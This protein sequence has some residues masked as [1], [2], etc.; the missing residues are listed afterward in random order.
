MT[1]SPD[2]RQ[3]R[4]RFVAFSFAAADLLMEIEPEHGLIQFV[5]GAAKS[6]TGKTDAELKNISLYNLLLPADR[7]LFRRFL[8]RIAHGGRVQPLPIKIV[9]GPGDHKTV[10]MGGCRLPYSDRFYV[11]VVQINKSAVR[12]N[13]GALRDE[14][15]GLL[16][17]D[18]FAEKAHSL[19]ERQT[20]EQGYQLTFIE[21]PG[22]D[23]LAG[24]M[25]REKMEEL[26]SSIGAYLRASSA[27][28]DAATVVEENRYGVVHAASITASDLKA[29]IEELTR[30]YDPAH[31]GIEG[32]T[33]EVNLNV[34][35][36]GAEDTTKAFIY[37]VNRFAETGAANLSMASLSE[38]IAGLMEETVTRLSSYRTTVAGDNFHVVFQPIVSLVDGKVHHYEALS[39]FNGGRNPFE[40]ISFAEE[41]GMIQEFDLAVC[42]KVMDHL[43]SLNATGKHYN[44]AINLS[45]QSLE[46]S[47]FLESL[48]RLLVNHRALRKQILFELTESS[49]IHNFEYVN[50]ALQ[51]LRREGHIVCL[52]DVG[53]GATSFHYIRSLHV[54]F[55]KIDGSYIRNMVKNPRDV[56]FARAIANLAHDLNIKTIAEMVETEEEASLLRVMQVNFAQGWLF[57]KPAPLLA[58]ETPGLKKKMPAAV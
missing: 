45:A 37:A 41:V 13:E 1:P 21:L 34:A 5:S 42:Q 55:I 27:D 51:S 31:K 11:S 30:E 48:R 50:N 26:Y 25:P 32:I 57:G 7:N 40:V 10:L 15:T 29:Y 49:E 20:G 6:I 39:R 54:D 24:R 9:R 56:A 8:G 3:E 19:L 12:D 17:K 52:D 58:E 53:A 16:D 36:L 47:I 4:D 18:S 38:S 23:E 2:V 43:I 44:I 14:S 28:G 22:L 46:S 33:A 35:E